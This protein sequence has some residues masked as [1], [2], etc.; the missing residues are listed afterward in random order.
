LVFKNSLLA[1]LSI[2]LT[3]VQLVNASGSIY[4]TQYQQVNVDRLWVTI[5]GYIVPSSSLRLNSY[6]NLS[7]LSEI[8]TCDEVIITS[9]RPFIFK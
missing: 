6:N 9:M 4:V 3:Q 8:K 2:G 7:I 5:N 1:K